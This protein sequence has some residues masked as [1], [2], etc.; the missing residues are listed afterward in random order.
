MT[1]VATPQFGWFAAA[2]AFAREFGGGVAWSTQVGHWYARKSTYPA[3]WPLYTWVPNGRFV[4][5]LLPVE[6]RAR[7][8][9][10]VAATV[11]AVSMLL[12]RDGDPETWEPDAHLDD[13]R[14]WRDGTR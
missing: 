1:G 3:D 4:L 6:V 2:E 13:W 11:H 10:G 5:D 7:G 9:A 8:A 12:A 14:P